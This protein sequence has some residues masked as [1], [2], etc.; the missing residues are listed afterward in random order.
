MSPDHLTP[1]AEEVAPRPQ[2]REDYTNT[3]LKKKVSH[4]QSAMRSG[5]KNF[6]IFNFQLGLILC[7]LV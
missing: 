5:D 3:V 1:I 4:D 7:V 6:F 2:P